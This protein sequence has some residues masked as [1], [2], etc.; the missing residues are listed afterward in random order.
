MNIFTKTF[1]VA[2]L[3][4]TIPL[5]QSCFNA[6]TTLTDIQKITT[7]AENVVTAVQT[8][9]CPS[10][11]AKPATVCIAQGTFNQIEE[12]LS[13]L[14]E[15]NAK[16]LAID[17]GAAKLDAAQVAQIA[18]DYAGVALGNLVL[19]P[20]VAFYVAAA[21]AAVQI[22][23]DAIGVKPAIVQAHAVRGK[24]AS[25]ATYPFRKLAAGAAYPIKVVYDAQKH[26]NAKV[27]NDSLGDHIAK[28]H[29]H[30]MKVLAAK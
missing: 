28:L 1:I 11:V 9:L 17:A 22:V 18:E 30:A 10:G 20:Q 27:A 19:P 2:I 7:A 15:A 13:A 29:A 5:Q 24:V 12:W 26:H 21:E 25:V 14:Q 23:L 16:A 8:N 3:A 6:D 4:V